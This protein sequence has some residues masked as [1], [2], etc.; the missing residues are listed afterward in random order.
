MKS[1]LQISALIFLCSVAAALLA[2]PTPP[3]PAIDPTTGLPVQ[4]RAGRSQPQMPLAFDPQTGQPIMPT[5]PEWKDPDWKDPDIRLADVDI[6]GLP[7]GEVAK[8]IRDR[9]KGQFD[10][11]LPDPTGDGINHLTD[12]PVP[13]TDWRNENMLNLKLKDV[14]ASELFNAMNLTFEN[15]KT[16]LQWELKVYGHRQ[17]ALLRVLVDPTPPRPPQDHPELRPPPQPE[18]QRRV[19]FVGDLIGDEKNGGMTMDQIV[20]TIT[21]IWQMTDTVNGKIQFHNEAQLLVVTG[22]PSQIDFLEQTLAALHRK[23][24][25]ARRELKNSKT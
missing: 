6:Q 18:P 19:Y 23:V 13:P 1:K 20:K 15:D 24:D 3:I 22:T 12:L 5:Q 16:P 21:D 11:I 2:E 10:I 17:I 25:Q 14:S 8:F 9:F 4:N 7:I